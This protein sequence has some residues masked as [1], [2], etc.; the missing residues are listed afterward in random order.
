MGQGQGKEISLSDDGMSMNSFTDLNP[1]I[2]HSSC[3]TIPQP[4]QFYR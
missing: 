3:F 2:E 1:L 4:F